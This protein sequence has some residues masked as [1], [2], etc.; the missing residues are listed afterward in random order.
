MFSSLKFKIGITAFIVISVIMSFTTLRDISKSEEKLLNTQKEKA[1]LLS[2]RI[3]NGIMALMLQNRWKDLQEMM[4]GMV[5]HSEDLKE[6]RIFNPEDGLIVVSSRED[7]IGKKIYQEDM[8]R[9]KSGR[10]EDAF[11]IEKSGTK[12]A[13]RLTSIPNLPACHRCHGSEKKVLGVLDLELSVSHIYQSLAQIKREHFFSALIG[14]FLIMGT[15]LI[16]TRI[17]IGKPIQKIVTAIKGVEGGDLSVRLDAKRKDEIGQ[18]SDSFN[19]MVESLELAREEIE[20][21]HNQQMRRAAKLASLGEMAS[22]IAHEIKN[23]LAGI[24]SAVQV[25]LMELDE[26]D[27]KKKVMNEILNQV[28]RLDRAVKDLL[29]YARPSPPN[30]A[31][32]NIHIVLEKALFF[33]QQVAKKGQTN[34]ETNFQEDLP[35]VMVDSDQLQQVFINISINAVQAMPDGGT[36]KISTN[37]IT[38]DSK[39]PELAETG[40]RDTDWIKVSFED[41]GVGIS[42]EDVKKIFDP[43]YTKKGKGTGLGLAISQRIVEEHGGKITVLSEQGKGSTFSVYLPVE[44]NQ[45]NA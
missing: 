42:A 38:N 4:E 39:T 3:T 27:P 16:V 1:V 24:N 34:I 23:P 14:F 13:S 12:Y 41:T 2:E 40:N 35:E 33:V 8:E 36:L 6:I 44:N 45:G 28:K 32:Q 11:Y 5:R 15:F 25:L 17:L 20:M 30:K 31:Y 18:L 29:A 43:F 26:N 22:A 7:E 10:G 37:L 21:C 9:F 19:R